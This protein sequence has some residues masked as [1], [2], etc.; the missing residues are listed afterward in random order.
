MSKLKTK[1]AHFDRETGKSIYVYQYKQHRFVGEAQCHEDD[2]DMCS[3][4]VGLKLAETR[5]FY[6]F[7]KVKRSELEIRLQTLEGMV[8]NM[9]TSKSFDMTSKY[10][11]KLQ[12]A[13]CETRLELQDCREGIKNIPKYL[14]N[15]IAA[16]DAL[17][18]KLRKRRGRAGEA[19]KPKILFTNETSAE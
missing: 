19:D 6:Q 14:Q 13:I 16:R 15:D 8:Q 5:A 3:E 11:R 17:Y 10:G 4:L 1:V 9:L 7:L 12:W 2:M 18:V